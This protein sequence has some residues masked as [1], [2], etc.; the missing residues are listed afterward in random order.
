VTAVVYNLRKGTTCSSVT[1][2]PSRQ[3]TRIAGQPSG[4]SGTGAYAVDLVGCGIEVG[5]QNQRRPCGRERPRQGEDYILSP[6]EISQRA[7]GVRRRIDQI[8][9]LVERV[10]DRNNPGHRE[11]QKRSGGSAKSNI[12]DVM[13]KPHRQA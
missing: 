10:L 8:F 4:S 1:S 7:R 9:A 2:S 3:W 6:E 11:P 12:P 13:V 5:G